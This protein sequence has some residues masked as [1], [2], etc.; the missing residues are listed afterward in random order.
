MIRR[1]KISDKCSLNSDLTRKPLNQAVALRNFSIKAQLIII[2]SAAVTF[3]CFMTLDPNP[4]LLLSTCAAVN[5]A[6]ML[7][8]MYRLYQLD[9]LLSP[10]ML[11]YIGPSMLL[12]YSWGNLGARMAGETRYAAVFGTFDYY[13]TVAL[14]STIGL[15][16]YCW[17]VFGVFQQFFLSAK[18]KYQDLYWKPRQVLIAMFIGLTILSYLSTKYT[19]VGGNFRDATSHFDRWLIATIN[20]LAYLLAIISVSVL[21]RALDK[22][23]RLIAILGIILSVLL[24]LG[25]RSRTFM[26]MVLLLLSLCWITL[27]PNQLRLSFFLWVGLFSILIFSLGTAIKSLQSETDSIVDNLSYVVA[28]EP[29]QIIERAQD[30]IGTDR[31]YRT[32]GFEYPAVILMCLDKGA[33]P[34]FGEGLMGAALQGLPGFIRPVGTV[35]ERGSIVLHFVKYCVFRDDLMAIPLVSGIADW[36]LLGV[37]FYILMGVF[38]L[39]LWRFSQISPRFFLIFLLV[40]IFPDSLFWTGVFTYIKTMGFL[41]LILLITGPV[42]LPSWSP[43]KDNSNII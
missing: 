13:P 16:L 10:M 7:S 32:G 43:S 33:T 4:N 40:P 25:F 14:L 1:Q 39:I 41:W 31:Q 17:V 22:R 35:D 19:F 20:T 34:G 15:L 12:Y 11:V 21:A 37:F 27:K 3:F 23:S 30:G 6:I 2:L 24:A 8:A 38:S 18:I 42:I 29:S 9:L 36:G 28:L 5:V 26:V